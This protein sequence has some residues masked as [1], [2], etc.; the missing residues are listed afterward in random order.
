MDSLRTLSVF[1][2]PKIDI[3]GDGKQRQDPL[4]TSSSMLCLRDRPGLE[5]GSI[6]TI[7]VSRNPSLRAGGLVGRDWLEVRVHAD[8]TEL[9]TSRAWQ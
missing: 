6:S 3:M 9:S 8:G 5:Q 1:R 2:G 7:R 4:L